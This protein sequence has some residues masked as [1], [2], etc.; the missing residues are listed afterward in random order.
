MATD[1]QRAIGLVT[2]LP[3]EAGPL[4]R[5]LTGRSVIRTG[6]WRFDQGM[7][8]PLGAHVGCT[9]D[10]SVSS[11]PH[12]AHCAPRAAAAGR[13]ARV[14]LVRSGMGRARAALAC[15]ALLDHFDVDCVAAV[16][17][18][19]ALTPE[20][21]PGALLW[22]D[23]VLTFPDLEHAAGATG[24]D[25]LNPPADVRAMA[26]VGPL[27]TTDRVLCRAAAKAELARWFSAAL[28]EPRST[29][30]EA[31][32]GR[33]AGRPAS[34][35]LRAPCSALPAREA[36]DGLPLAVDMETAGAA[37]V[38][39]A[40]DVPFAAVRVVTDAL[41]H[42]LPLDFNRCIGPRGD[43]RGVSIAAQLARHPRALPGLLRL[44]HHSLA[45]S[46]RLAAF[47]A[48]ALPHL[49]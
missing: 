25:C 21:A 31:S 48:A 42:D 16:G 2:A 8:A 13:S 10:L 5:A 15:A 47:L 44:G 18:A 45:A 46:R 4:R 36:L 34:L 17:F 22:A 41:E 23:R 7:L 11:E 49:P 19:G 6:E 38:A 33:T 32:S 1:S 28:R 43:V 35:P 26:W 29:E 3:E 40:R 39:A 37:E 27:V 9:A 20:L 12:T 14:I 24:F 30:H